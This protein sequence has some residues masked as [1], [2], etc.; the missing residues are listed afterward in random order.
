M[1]RLS[2]KL[3]LE[4]GWNAVEQDKY[5]KLGTGLDLYVISRKMGH[6]AYAV[7]KKGVGTF[8]IGSVEQLNLVISGVVYPPP[9]QPNNFEEIL[10]KRYGFVRDGHG[11]LVLEN[12]SIKISSARNIMFVSYCGRT[13]AS[14]FTSYVNLILKLY[15][16]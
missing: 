6:Y 11:S 14:S 9:T 16:S 15:W 2:K 10:C 13:I 8:G 7:S 3:L 1:T 5:K 12:E 4:Q